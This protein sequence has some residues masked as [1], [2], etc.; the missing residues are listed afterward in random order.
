MNF[1]RYYDRN[2]NLTN[3]QNNGWLEWPGIGQL[4]EL[5]PGICPKFT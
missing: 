4:H 5:A 3:I 2:H 1:D